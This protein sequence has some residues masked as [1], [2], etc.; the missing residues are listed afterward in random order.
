M[1][2]FVNNVIIHLIWVSYTGAIKELAH[3]LS[4]D[5]SSYEQQTRTLNI[6]P[7]SRSCNKYEGL[8]DNADLEVY[9]WG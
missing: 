3:Q 4:N 9:C 2:I 7:A 5:K 8:A 1:S 6:R